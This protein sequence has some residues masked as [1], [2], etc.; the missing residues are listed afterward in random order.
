MVRTWKTSHRRKRSQRRK[1]SH[2]KTSHRMMTWKIS[3]RRIRIRKNLRKA[4]T[5]RRTIWKT[6]RRIRRRNF[7][8]LSQMR[9][10]DL[11]GNC[12]S[13]NL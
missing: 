12:D 8:R 2:R 3:H 9:S 6:R 1:R 5:S 11:V 7:D 4:R 10:S 13:A